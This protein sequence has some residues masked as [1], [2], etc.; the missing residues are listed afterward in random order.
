MRPQPA[1]NTTCRS[2][3]ADA[4]EMRICSVEIVFIQSRPIF[5]PPVTGCP[6]IAGLCR[7]VPTLHLSIR[8]QHL[9]LNLLAPWAELLFCHDATAWIP[10]WSDGAGYRLAIGKGSSN[11]WR[12]FPEGNG[13]EKSCS[14]SINPRAENSAT[15]VG[16]QDGVYRRSR[17]RRSRR[18]GE[19]LQ[20]CLPRWG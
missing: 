6:L 12:N 14:C 16:R 15:G 10:V 4:R 5:V 17:H 19:G 13:S 8:H 20:V 9:N 2:I 7:P 3:D 11:S 18:H 1:W